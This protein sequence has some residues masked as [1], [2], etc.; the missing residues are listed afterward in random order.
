VKKQTVHLIRPSVGAAVRPN[1][2][3][4]PESVYG[5]VSLYSSTSCAAGASWC[6]SRRPSSWPASSSAPRRPVFSPTSN[7]RRPTKPPIRTSRCS[8]RSDSPHR[9]SV[10]PAVSAADCAGRARRSF[11]SVVQGV[12]GR[13]QW[14]RNYGDRTVHC[15]FQVQDFMFKTSG[16][17]PPVT[18]ESKMRLMSK[19]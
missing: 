7:A 5:R 17:V 10:T 12:S 14:R 2:L 6:R 4:V 8:K 16:L 1:T 13:N 15:I 18:P 11:A 19:F 9:R 3:N